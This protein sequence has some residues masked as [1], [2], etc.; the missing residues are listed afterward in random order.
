MRNHAVHHHAV[1]LVS[2]GSREPRS[3]RAAALLADRLALVLRWQRAR[4]GIAQLECAAQPLHDQISR[5]V[6]DRRGQG[7]IAH[8]QIL[9]LF[10]SAGVHARQDLPAQVDLAREQLARS[11]WRGELVVAPPLGLWPGW[12]EWLATSWA[13]LSPRTKASDFGRSTQPSPPVALGSIASPASPAP[14]PATKILLAHG[15]RRPGGNAAVES[16]AKHLGATP[17]YWS[18]APSLADR[19]AE[20]QIQRQQNLSETLA[21]NEATH[22]GAID[23]GSIDSAGINSTAIGTTAVNTTAIDTT[24]IEVLPYFLFAGSLTEAIAAQVAILEKQIKQSL[25]PLPTSAD[26]E[27]ATQPVVDG[28]GSIDPTA[29]APSGTGKPDPE[30]PN[31][32]N[33]NASVPHLSSSS[34]IKISLRSPIGPTV[35]LAKFLARWVVDHAKLSTED[36]GSLTPTRSQP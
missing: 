19:L 27:A 23:S 24:A 36:S 26:Q 1:L 30:P 3:Q 7:S 6:S 25:L 15:S 35:S 11:G 34:N 31:T 10:L 28:P 17:A 2:H 4:V 29:S 33:P 18:V 13:S 5:F 12:Q 16:L 8:C 22:S 32:A 14:V 21:Q 20:W 9:P